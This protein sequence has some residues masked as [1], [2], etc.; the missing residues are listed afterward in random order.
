MYAE[1]MMPRFFAGIW[2]AFNG[3]I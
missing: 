2:P 3:V 1:A